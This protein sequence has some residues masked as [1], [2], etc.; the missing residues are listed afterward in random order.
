MPFSLG[1]WATAGAGG[2]A[3]D[4]MELIS[5]S[6]VGST[7]ASVTFS[8]IPQTY[9]HLQIRW[10]GRNSVSWGSDGSANMLWL[11]VNG[12]S[13]ASYSAH[14]LY[15]DGSSV[16][17]AA[18]SANT[19]MRITNAVANAFGPSN[20]FGGGVIDFFDYTNTS[21][22]KMLKM[23]GGYSSGSPEYGRI[24]LASAGYHSTGA[25]TSLTIGPGNG[26]GAGG[27]WISGGRFSLYG[28][29]GA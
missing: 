13:S 6:L 3:A 9:K 25:I 21:T 7:T 23:L 29:K 8:S 10:T 12:S 2:A 28:I 17:S 11:Q 26:P 15:G 20:A 27:N 4:A 19:Y 14:M 16:S 22:N 1:F 24:N 5:T 18:S